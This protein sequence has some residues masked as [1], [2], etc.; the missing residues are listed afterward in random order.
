LHS[1]VQEKIEMIT[2]KMQQ[3]VLLLLLCVG[4]TTLMQQQQQALA[5]QF[6]AMQQ[7]NADE[8]ATLKEHM[9]AMQTLLEK[10]AQQGSSD[11]DVQACMPE[12]TGSM[13]ALSG[14][15]VQQVGD[16]CTALQQEVSNSLGD[17]GRH[18]HQLALNFR[19][20]GRVLQQ[21]SADVRV[22]KEGQDKLILEV[23]SAFDCSSLHSLPE[24]APPCWF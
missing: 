8:A 13:L 21:V 17:V 3:A 6:A 2:G 11:A 12:F 4:D 7:A 14:R 15:A 5:A 19:S 22:I 16:A 20:F 9:A 24:S 23:R 18:V 10:L 1:Y